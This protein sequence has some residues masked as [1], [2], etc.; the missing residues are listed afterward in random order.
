MMRA[1]FYKGTRP[2]I[3]G[4]YN[5]VVRAWE[6]GAHSHVELVFSDGVAASA[7]LMDKGV[8]FKCIEWNADNWDFIEL[9]QFSENRA[10]GWFIENDGAPYDLLGQLHFIALPVQGAD[11]KF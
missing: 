4:A 1:A 6:S 8:R 7:S 3:A 11:D 9:P 10:R 2:G 5:R